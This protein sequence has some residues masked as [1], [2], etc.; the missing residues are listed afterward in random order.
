VVRHVGVHRADDAHVVD[1]FGGVL[2]E[3]ADGDAALAVLL[4]LE[5][6]RERAAGW[7]FRAQ[8]VH[9]QG[10]ARVLFQRGFG[11]PGV[12]VR[13]AAVQ[14]DVDDALGFGVVV[15]ELGGGGRGGSAAD[16]RAQ[17]H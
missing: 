2:E 12:D 10:F 5:H 13:A 4:E 16:Q 7:A 6:A 8:V 3:F 11:I 1:A 9:R 17:A 14:E 15:G